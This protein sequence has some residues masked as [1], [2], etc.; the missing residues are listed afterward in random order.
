MT[1]EEFFKKM[2]NEANDKNKAEIAYLMSRYVHTKNIT[3]ILK[4]TNGLMDFIDSYYLMHDKKIGF[5]DGDEFVEVF[6]CEPYDLGSG[7]MELTATE[8]LKEFLDTIECKKLVT[9]FSFA[10]L[11]ER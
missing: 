7:M 11:K 6:I 8:K 9:E 5:Y 3:M 4:D 1:M 2:F 10:L